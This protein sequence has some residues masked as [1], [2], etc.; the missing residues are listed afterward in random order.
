MEEGRKQ[1]KA[2]TEGT[3][4]KDEDPYGGST[5]ENTDAEAE[6]DHP[7]PELPGMHQLVPIQLL[8]ACVL[9]SLFFLLLYFSYRL[10]STLLD[11]LLPTLSS[12]LDF[13][14]GKHFFLY[15][16]FPNNDRRLLLRY[17]VA[18]NG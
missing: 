1:K 18:F 5:D 8:A 3:V 12:L 11:L 7:I 4:V 9:L 6:E 16:K 17:I 13:L 2:A 14:S 15:G 10:C